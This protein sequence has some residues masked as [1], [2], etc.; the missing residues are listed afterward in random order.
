MDLAIFLVIDAVLLM[1]ATA[2]LTYYFFR[3]FIK[4]KSKQDKSQK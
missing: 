2:V 4:E 3:D 1:I